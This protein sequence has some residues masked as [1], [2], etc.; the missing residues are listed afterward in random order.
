MEGCKEYEHILRD[1]T[2]RTVTADET[3][4]SDTPDQVRTRLPSH[5]SGN[6]YVP[7][8]NIR[9]S[10]NKDPKQ[11]SLSLEEWTNTSH[12]CRFIVNLLN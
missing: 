10:L 1:R 12:V 2:I 3:K 6:E 7:L 8:G 9:A 4:R 11:T 5:S